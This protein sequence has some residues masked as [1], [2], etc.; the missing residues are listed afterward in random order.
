MSPRQT[1]C[2]L[3]VSYDLEMNQAAPQWT[4]TETESLVKIIYNV[5]DTV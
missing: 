4:V 1:C 2:L 5:N 3:G